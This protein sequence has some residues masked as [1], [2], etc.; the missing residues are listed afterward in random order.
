MANT[1]RVKGGGGR[2]GINFLQSLKMQGVMA[3]P[4]CHIAD[5]SGI[6]RNVTQRHSNGVGIASILG[7]QREVVVDEMPKGSVVAGM[8]F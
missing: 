8:H 5:A 2:K 4:G 3:I 7:R 6:E 1:S